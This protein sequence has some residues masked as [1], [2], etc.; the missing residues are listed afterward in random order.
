MPSTRR[1][2][3]AL[4]VEDDADDAALIERQLRVGGFDVTSLRVGSAA[5]TRD[6]LQ[7]AAWDVILADFTLPGF[8]GVEVLPMLAEHGLDAPFIIVS[9]T[10]DVATALE[11]M[12][13]GA[14]DYVLKAELERLPAVVERELESARVQRK[15]RIAETERDQALVDLQG[16]NQE[17]RALAEEIAL[18]YEAEHRVA[19]VLQEALLALPEAVPGIEFAAR[20]ASGSDNTRVGGDFYDLFEIDHGRVGILVGDVSGKGLEAA[21]LTSVVRNS[22]RMRSMDGLTPA[23][24]M[25]KTNEAFY[26]LTSTETFVTA[27]YGVLDVGTGRLEYVGAGHPPAMVR[28]DA[29]DVEVLGSTGPIVGAFLGTTFAGRCADLSAGDVLFVYT[30]GVIEA[31]GSGPRLY[32]QERLRTVLGGVPDGADPGV[33]A[34]AVFEDVLAYS[35]GKMRDD[36]ALLAIRLSSI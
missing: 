10:I 3:R 17:L 29:A 5:E 2:L 15:R 11:A 19:E 35:G 21:T 28:R 7:S 20:Y 22:V 24:T 12:K 27:F 31:R 6:A 33:V 14:R 1:P 25:T 9:G 23:E 36:L 26:A 32:G 34:D 16:A 4:L 18:R 30:D 13:A 8:R